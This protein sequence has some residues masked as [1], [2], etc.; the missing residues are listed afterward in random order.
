MIQIMR[1]RSRTR[2]LSLLPSTRLEFLQ[3]TEAMNL[4]LKI[5]RPESQ[6]KNCDESC[7]VYLGTYCI[8]ISF[9]MQRIF[10][11]FFFP[12]N[13]YLNLLDLGS[14]FSY[15]T[16]PIHG[17]VFIHQRWEEGALKIQP[18]L[19]SATCEINHKKPLPQQSITDLSWF[20]VRCYNNNNEVCRAISALRGPAFKTCPVLFPS[21]FQSCLYP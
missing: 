16:C 11:F 6:W 15:P 1:L 8:P 13:H 21:H 9:L 5:G 2:L 19:S 17:W 7:T 14:K 12:L 20:F 18:P 3:G 10:F 4:N